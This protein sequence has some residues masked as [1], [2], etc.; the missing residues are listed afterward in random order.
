MVL[1]LSEIEDPCEQ[2]DWLVFSEQIKKEV[3]N[4]G[5]RLETKQSVVLCL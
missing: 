4:N 5:E 1:S 2:F 3:T